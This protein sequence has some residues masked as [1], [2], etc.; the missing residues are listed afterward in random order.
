MTDINACAEHAKLDC[1]LRPKTIAIIGAS[2]N[3]GALGFS[4]FENLQKHGFAGQIHLVNPKYDE[5]AGHPCHRDIKGLPE[6]IDAAVLA[7]PRQAV[8]AAMRSLAAKKTKGVIIF[9]AGF[10]ED[11]PDGQAEQKEL[12]RIAH[13]NGMVVDGPNCLGIIGFDH[14]A[15]LTFIK[16]PLMQEKFGRKIAIVSQ[17]GAM[18]AVLSVSLTARDLP[19]SYSISTGNEAV[20]GVE[21]FLAAL[22]D[23]KNVDVFAMIVE[24]F[25]KPKDFLTVARHIRSAGKTIVLLHPGKSAEARESAATHTGAMAG[26]YDLMKVMVE[27]AGVLLVNDLEELIDVCDLLSRYGPFRKGR[28]VIVTESGAYKALALD[29]C[30]SAGL[31][32]AKLDI[33]RHTELRCVLPPF[34]ALSNPVDLTAQGL[35]EPSIYGRVI[36]ALNK[37]ADI[38]AIFLPIIQTDY[39]T[40]AIKYPEVI[41]ALEA[42]KPQC[43]ILF[44]GLDDGAPVPAD[45]VQALRRN[46]ASYFT[47][48]DRAIR[49]LAQVSKHAEFTDEPSGETSSPL[50]LDSLNDLGIIAEYRAKQLLALTGFS[51]PEGALVHSADEAVAVAEKIGFPV[52]VKAQARSLPHKS[53]AGGVIVNIPDAAGLRMAW[54]QLHNNVAKNRPDVTLDGVLIE[55]MGARGLE[56][57]IGAKRDPLWGPVILVGAGGVTAELYHDHCLIPADL[58]RRGIEH[59]L[60]GLKCIALLD[61]FRG[62]P[63]GDKKSV[64][65]LILKLAAIMRASPTIAEID[66]NPVVVYENG[67]GALA[68]DAL[69]RISGGE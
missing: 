28:S 19:L 54:Q 55:K 9:S 49:A 23:D 35:V 46:G 41:A 32:L 26:D 13:D 65:E 37:D 16:A 12:A 21:D 7:I 27:Q 43:P 1:L 62:T 61:G 17:S 53:D 50:P 14:H 29:L 64:V 59:A 66:L 36:K 11:G 18:S 63:P 44:A 10:A 58:D 25:R 15:P 67:K 4:V 5:I 24:Q 20:N 47:S 45:Y 40:C 39:E 8:L 69:M 2:P 51:F 57:I 33:N 30:E 42:I 38:N 31:A 60:D 56:L 34:V 6:N 68:L 3:A 48:P 22:A 52:V